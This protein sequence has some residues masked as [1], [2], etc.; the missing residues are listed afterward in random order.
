MHRAVAARKVSAGSYAFAE[1]LLEGMPSNTMT[2]SARYVAM[3]KSCSTTNAVFLAWRMYLKQT[4][5]GCW[6]SWTAQ[7]GA[8]GGSREGGRRTSTS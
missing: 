7:E 8:S 4:G 6:L 2:L 5:Q 1:V 3:M